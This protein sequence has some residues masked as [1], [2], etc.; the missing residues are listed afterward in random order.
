MNLE[1]AVIAFGKKARES[2][3]RSKD[4]RDSAEYRD[5]RPCFALRARGYGSFFPDALNEAGE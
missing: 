1:I 5:A 4:E 2:E 3:A